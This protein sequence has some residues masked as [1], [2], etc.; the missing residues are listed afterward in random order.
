[1][2][3]KK[4]KLAKLKMPMK[5]PDEEEDM[6][7]MDMEGGEEGG[8]ELDM[9]MAEPDEAEMKEEMG[10]GAASNLAAVSDDELLAEMKKRG[11][12]PEDLGAPEEASDLEEEA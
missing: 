3:M 12:K 8:D 7:M 5:R 9:A 1:M 10:E 4:S 6:D 11:L 2:E